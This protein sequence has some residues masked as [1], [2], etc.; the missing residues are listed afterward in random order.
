MRAVVCRSKTI[1]T[2]CAAYNTPPRTVWT[3]SNALK[4]KKKQSVIRLEFRSKVLQV[5]PKV[6]DTED[7][8]GKM[9]KVVSK[10]LRVSTFLERK[11]STPALHYIMHGLHE[12]I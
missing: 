1:C 5:W 4:K 6:V 9:S 3:C 2:V 11:L 10:K 8:F 12:T 7:S